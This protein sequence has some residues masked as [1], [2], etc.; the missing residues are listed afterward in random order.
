MTRSRT[1]LLALAVLGGGC[2]IIVDG[3]LNNGNP[4]V[5][6]GI[7]MRPV[8]TSTAQCL[9]LGD[10]E[11][12]CTQL[13]VD[14]R[15]T[16][17]LRTPDGTGCGT[18]TPQ[19]CVDS[20]CGPRRCGDSFR[21]RLPG[22]AMPE[23]C[24]DGANGNPMDG[25]NDDCTRPCGPGIPTCDDGDPCNG[26]ETCVANLCQTTAQLMPGEGCST[27]SIASGTCQLMQ[28]T[29]LGSLRCMAP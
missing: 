13:C 20:A 29:N 11:F 26:V 19:I 14:N 21:D 5:D 12:D 9:M 15:C 4:D 1:L 3:Q 27:T 10:R 7:D 17:G 18:G 28:P 23:F 6:G 2:S 25:C 22:V 24:D 8:C 16:R